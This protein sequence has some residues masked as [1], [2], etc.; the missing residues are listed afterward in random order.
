[1]AIL[2]NIERLQDRI[3]TKCGRFSP[4]LESFKSIKVYFMSTASILES[5][6]EIYFIYHIMNLE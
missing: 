5:T 6:V 2:I 4:C 3:A 1:M